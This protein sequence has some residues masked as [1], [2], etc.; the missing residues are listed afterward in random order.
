MSATF[1]I[2]ATQCQLCGFWSSSQ[3]SERNRLYILER[4]LY[5]H[6]VFE[7]DLQP[8]IPDPILEGPMK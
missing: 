1:E 5:A 6:N 3:D 8:S 2:H 4:F 7:A